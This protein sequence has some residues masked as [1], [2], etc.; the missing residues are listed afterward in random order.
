MSVETEAPILLQRIKEA[1]D[2]I[3]KAVIRTPCVYSLP[4]SRKAGGDV[5]L[6]LE[7]LQVTQAFKARG[8]A[9]KLALMSRE[10][11]ER[12]VITASSGNHGLGLSL[13]AKQHSVNA[14][15]VVPEVAPANKIE[16]IKENGAE[17]I[18]NGKAYDDAVAFAHTMAEKEG[19]VYVPSFDDADIIAGNGSVGLEILE[20]VSD[21]NLIVCPI[22]G[23]G[24]ISGVSLAV[25]Q[26]NPDIRV[27]GVEA[28]QAPSMLRSVEAGELTELPSASTF[29][30]GIAVR[31]PGTLNFEIVKSWVDSIVTVSEEAMEAAV[32]ILAKEAKIVAEGA[33]AASVAALLTGRLDSAFD[34]IVC[35]ISGGNIDMDRFKRVLDKSTGN[36]R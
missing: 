10:E 31:K 13:A 30:D 1:R 11:R 12:G 24:G 16:K 15:V 17:V 18:I 36:P 20:D 22:G 35:I 26:I 14:V 9:N 3:A 33:G 7:C 6:K 23:G 5:F 27:V 28:E 8:N 25:K 29:A 4:L 21:V 2:R 34:K 32:V 19:L